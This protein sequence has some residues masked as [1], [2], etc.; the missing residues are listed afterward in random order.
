MIWRDVKGYEGLYQISEYGDVKSLQKKNYRKL[1]Q[2]LVEIV[3][4]E[5]IMATSNKLR[6]KSIWVCKKDNS[7][8]AERKQIHIMVYEAF[9]GEIEKDKIIDHIDENRYN[10]HY[11]NLQMITQAENVVKYFNNYY[12]DKYFDDGKI[13]SKCKLKKPFTE[14]YKRKDNSGT[15]NEYRSR[16]KKCF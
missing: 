2:G 11:T 3:H 5:K 8:K 10:N 14:F 1:K 12:R 16:C 4:K 7:N 15:I 6:Y 13:C 9:I